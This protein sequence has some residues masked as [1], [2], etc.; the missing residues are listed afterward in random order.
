MLD[1]DIVRHDFS[2]KIHWQ[3]TPDV[4]LHYRREK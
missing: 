2:A 4:A 1:F 3:S